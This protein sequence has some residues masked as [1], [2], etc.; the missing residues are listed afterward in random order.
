MQHYV[1]SEIDVLKKEAFN[2]FKLVIYVR[3]DKWLNDEIIIITLISEHH[4]SI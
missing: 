4:L 2:V 3:T 1:R